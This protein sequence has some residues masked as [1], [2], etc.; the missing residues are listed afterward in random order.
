MSVICPYANIL[1]RKSSTYIIVVFSAKY[2]SYLADNEPDEYDELVRK[3]LA[4]A[5][6]ANKGT[7]FI[8]ML[9]QSAKKL[10]FSWKVRHV[11]VDISDK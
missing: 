3:S 6:E 4:P 1:Q 7:H 5:R 11:P 10:L 8:W 2:S 9:I